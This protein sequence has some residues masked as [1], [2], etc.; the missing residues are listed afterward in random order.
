MSQ[1]E[2]QKGAA[3]LTRQKI[4]KNFNKLLGQNNKPTG[5][6]G[7]VMQNFLLKAKDGKASVTTI[8]GKS[9][10][11]TRNINISIPILE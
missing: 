4:N 8:A 6:R 7:S 3:N 2:D 9:T 1:T 5:V 11:V 10:A